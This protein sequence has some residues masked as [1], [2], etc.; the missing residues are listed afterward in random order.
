MQ[1]NLPSGF[2][3]KFLP[4]ADAFT[5]AYQA[6]RQ[7][8]ELAQ[9]ADL[10]FGHTGPLISGC[11]QSH[12]P[13]PIKHQLRHLAHEV[14]RLLEEASLNRPRYVRQSTMQSLRSAIIARD[15]RGFYG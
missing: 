11:V 2:G 4:A 13:E 15:G 1:A 9:A 12:Y 10:M 14:T 6:S 8:S 5:Q 3:I 7:H